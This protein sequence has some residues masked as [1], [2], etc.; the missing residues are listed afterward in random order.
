MAQEIYLLVGHKILN[1]SVY[2]VKSCYPYLC[3]EILKKMY[4]KIEYHLMNNM[5]TINVNISMLWSGRK[6]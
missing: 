5:N 1:L 4:E 6:G 3:L 2:F